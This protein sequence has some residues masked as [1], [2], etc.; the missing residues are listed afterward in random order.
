MNTFNRQAFDELLKR[1]FFI[2]PSFELYG[3]VAGLYDYGPMGCSI[4]A[5]IISTWRQH[6][7]LEDN[8]L[9][10]DC[11]AMTPE[12]VLV[13]SGHVARFADVMVKDVVNGNCYRADHL[14]EDIMKKK[15]NDPNLPK[16]KKLEYEMIGQQADNYTKEEL[17]DIFQRFNIKAPGTGNDL[18]DPIDFNMMFA[19]SIGPTGSIKGYLRPETAQGIF[20]NFKRLQEFNNGRLPFAAA[21]IGKAFRNEIAPRSG[22]LRVR[23]FEMAEIE[24]FFNPNDSTHPKYKFIA[25]LE[26]PLF[27]QSTQLTGGNSITKTFKQ[28]M[29]DNT[30]KSETLAYYM[31]RVFLFMKRIGIDITRLR[32][33]QHLPN[34]MAHYAKDCWDCELHTSYGWIECVGIADRSCYDLTCH[35]KSTNTPLIA[36]EQ[37]VEPI[38]TTVI[39]AVSNKSIIGKHFKH[40]AKFII[41]YLENLT[42]EQ[43]DNMRNEL[44][45][46]GSVSITHN[47][48]TFTLDNSMITINTTKKQE[49]EH[50]YVPSVIEPSFGIGRILYSLLEHTYNL[51][52]GSEERAWFR[53]PQSIAPVKC[54]ILRLSNKPAFMP[55][56]ETIGTGLSKSGISYRMDDSSVSIGR[57]YAR[58][59]EI[60]IPFAITV[61]FQT[62][63]DN[64]VTIRDRD[65]MQQIRLSI[66]DVPSLIVNLLSHIITWNDVTIKYGLVQEIVNYD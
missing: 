41:D 10:V 51:R 65:S 53:L 47:N 18:S 22:L 8:M 43:A 38:I 21:Q 57:R 60:S 28:A 7:I 64:T 31:A 16:E 39:Q 32:F 34:E 3:G 5:N 59:D 52:E 20:L 14:L 17:S 26:V 24:H 48:N 40:D 25:D 42:N 23:E 19:T 1:R 55:F 49:Y 46:T 30:L 54:S 36:S 58:T 33:R 44:Q 15:A 56:L 37:L 11:T 62:L 12:P 9:E 13:S 63:E 29:A 35:S 50:K 66:S 61:D 45:Q 6:F 27:D 2:A 4:K